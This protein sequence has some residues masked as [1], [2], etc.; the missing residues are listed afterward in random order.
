M[1]SSRMDTAR[2]L[3]VSLECTPVLGRHPQADTPSILHPLLHPLNTTL[4]S[5]PPPPLPRE[6]TDACEDITF[7]S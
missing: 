3:T 5:I 2:Q 1:H 4:P 6:Q 7:S